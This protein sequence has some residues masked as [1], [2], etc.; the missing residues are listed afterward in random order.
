MRLG[1]GLKALGISLSNAT[2]SNATN[3]TANQIFGLGTLFKSLHENLTN[4]SLAVPYGSIAL[5]DRYA[6]AGSRMHYL[7]YNGSSGTLYNVTITKAQPNLNINING[8]DISSAKTSMSY[9][10]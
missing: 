1:A 7:G 3:L 4:S 9:L 2:W 5:T 8:Y 6:A 10:E